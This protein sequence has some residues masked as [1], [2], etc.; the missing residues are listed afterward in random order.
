M[1]NEPSLPETKDS[2]H[3]AFFAARIA[4]GATAAALGARRGG[5]LGVI[6]AACGGIALRS[7]LGEGWSFLR[8]LD[9]RRAAAAAA[10]PVARNVHDDDPWDSSPARD[11]PSYTR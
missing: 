5:V 4:L 3:I 6:V 9:R 8:E 2:Q 7:G 10:L 1:I 11:W